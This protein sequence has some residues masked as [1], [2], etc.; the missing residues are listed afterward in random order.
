MSMPVRRARNV[1]RELLAAAVSSVV[2]SGALPARADITATWTSATSGDWTSTSAWSTTPVYPN[3]GA[4]PGVNYLAQISATGSA[5]T[6]A[7]D[8]DITI[9][10][11]TINS[12]NATLDQTSGTFQAGNISTAAAAPSPTPRSIC[13]AAA[14]PFK[15]APST[16]SPSAAETCRSTPGAT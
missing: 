7:L 11:L 12:A 4:L 1:F 14:L 15:T 10:G 5:Y 3:N 8:S 9:D 13:P 16:A 2:I 6:V